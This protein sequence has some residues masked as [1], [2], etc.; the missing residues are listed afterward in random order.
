MKT[1]EEFD[2][3][4]SQIDRLKRFNAK[5]AIRKYVK[6][7]AVAPENVEEFYTYTEEQYNTYK[8]L[9]YAEYVSNELLPDS[10]SEIP[11]P[12]PEPIPEN[13]Y[14]GDYTIITFSNGLVSIYKDIENTFNLGNIYNPHSQKI[15][16]IYIGNKVQNV[17]NMGGSGSVTFPYVEKIVIGKNNKFFD[18]VNN[19][20]AI[21]NTISNTLILGCKNTTIIPDYVTSIGDYAF[22]NSGLSQIT[23]PDSVTSIGHHAFQSCALSQITIPDSVTSIG[24]QVFYQCN[25]KLIITYL[26]TIEQW[27]EMIPNSD[28]LG[29]ADGMGG[30]NVICSNGIIPKE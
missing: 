17:I 2:L 10:S 29:G 14:N 19:C 8:K 22:G 25:R 11:G 6:K 26:G 21:I 5:N 16:S 13:G 20:N 9:K 28:Y 23:I 15:I 3:T 12:I 4:Q 18:N 30:F 27:L 1:F 7:H 24:Y